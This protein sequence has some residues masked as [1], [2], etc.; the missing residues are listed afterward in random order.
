MGQFATP[1][2]IHLA[3]VQ[4]VSMEIHIPTVPP[5]ESNFV[6]QVLVVPTL[7]ATHKIAEK[8]ANVNTVSTEVHTKLVI[9]L[10]IL[11]YHHHADL[12]QTAGIT[13]V[14]LCA[15]ASGATKDTQSVIK[16]VNQIVSKMKIVPTQRLALTINAWIPVHLLVV[17]MLN[18]APKI[19]AP[20]ATVLTV[21]RV[22]HTFD[23][24]PE[25]RNLKRRILATQ[26][27][28]EPMPTAKYTEADQCVHVFKAIMVILLLAVSQSV[29][30]V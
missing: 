22:I 9:Q 2:E 21:S 24:F 28:V 11:A 4:V 3:T 8:S 10:L 25:S 1:P 27:H 6:V 19:T 15:P 7:I 12:I 5:P 13:M 20:C 29:S 16:V 18:V 17:L 14:E 26:H 23:V 30:P